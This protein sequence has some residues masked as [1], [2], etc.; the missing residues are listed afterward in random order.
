MPAFTRTIVFDQEEDL[1]V[2]LYKEDVTK[3]F[4]YDVFSPEGIYII[5]R[6]APTAIYPQAEAWGLLAF[7][8]INVKL[9]T[10]GRI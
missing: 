5:L 7:S 4:S 6:F 9:N 10:S 1:W 8:I 3:D 2:E